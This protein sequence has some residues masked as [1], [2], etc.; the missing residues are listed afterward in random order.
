MSATS[1]SLKLPV[2]NPSHFQYHSLFLHVHNFCWQQKRWAQL[3]TC[4]GVTFI[5]ILLSSYLQVWTIAEFKSGEPWC[6]HWG[7]GFIED[8][9]IC[10]LNSWT[11]GK[12]VLMPWAGHGACTLHT[13]NDCFLGCA[14]SFFVYMAL[15]GSS[16]EKCYL[17]KLGASWE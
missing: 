1:F 3:N 13:S 11:A 10:A 12:T 6:T 8:I 15:I 17:L 7:L 16:K 2:L 5:I 9:L 4:S 14:L